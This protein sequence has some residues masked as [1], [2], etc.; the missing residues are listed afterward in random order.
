MLTRDGPKV[1][2]FNCRF[3]DPETQAIL[4]VS[5]S[6][7]SLL[8]LMLASARNDETPD[9][10]IVTHDPGIAEFAE[11]VIILRDGEI[12]AD[13]PTARRGGPPVPDVRALSL[14]AT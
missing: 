13:Q 10:D 4:A 12:V 3:G 1:V 8:D 7:P 14:A 5:P 9:E 11:R 2:E 6:E